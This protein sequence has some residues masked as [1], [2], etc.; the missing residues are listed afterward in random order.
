ME[1]LRSDLGYIGSFM[2]TEG[3]NNLVSGTWEREIVDWVDK[4][5]K[6]RT[7]VFRENVQNFYNPLK[8]H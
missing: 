2:K 6:L 3:I 8:S 7:E 1:I 4:V 5:W